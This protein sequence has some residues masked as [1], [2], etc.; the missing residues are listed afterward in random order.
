MADVTVTSDVHTFMQSAN[1]AAMRT[2]IGAGTIATQNA[3]NVSITGGSVTGITDLAV[4]DGGTGASTASAARTNLEVYSDADVDAKVA[5]KAVAGGVYFQGTNGSSTLP[6]DLFYLEDTIKTYSF[7]SD[8]QQQTF[9]QYLFVSTE[10]SGGTTTGG[11]NI[12]LL[13]NSGDLRIQFR[14]AAGSSLH[15]AVNFLNV[16][17]G[18]KRHYVLQID[19]TATDPVI[20]CWVDGD[21][22][23]ATLVQATSGSRSTDSSLLNAYFGG[24]GAVS[25]SNAT[26]GM[27]SDLRIFNRALSAAE[28]AELYESGTVAVADRW[29][30]GAEGNTYT[31]DFSVNTD[32]FSALGTVLTGNIDSIGGE[33]DNLRVVANSSTGFKGTQKG[34]FLLQR[35]TYKVEY[36]VYL[37]GTNTEIVEVGFINPGSANA[38]SEASSRTALTDQWVSLERNITN[39]NSSA[40]FTITGIDSSGSTSSFTAASDGDTFYVRN[41]RITRK[42]CIADLPLDEG[43]GYQFHDRSS[44]HFDA[45]ASTTGV[46]HLV[47]KT[48]GKVRVKAADASSAMYM[49]RADSIL[50]TDSIISNVLSEQCYVDLTNSAQVLDDYRIRLNPSGSD[51]QIQRSDGSNHAT[52]GTVTAPSSLSDVDVEVH[53]E[54]VAR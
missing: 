6:V 49:L 52:L 28:V 19:T 9:V 33:D 34:G 5:T 50:P 32:S 51:L 26:V 12:A 41:V 37:L 30:D 39:L 4:A 10:A 21:E 15:Y 44:N 8:I 7:Y 18:N 11:L 27:L 13:A 43:I 42:G 48:E 3:N 2:N 47:P 35:N 1:Q 36:D 29:G 40:T 25:D 53:Y 38:D 16:A 46:T 45:L 17:N 23:T 31:S 24:K 20:K 22:Q 14:Q 54:Q